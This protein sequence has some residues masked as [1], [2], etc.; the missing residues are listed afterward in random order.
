MFGYRWSEGGPWD[1]DNIQGVVR[2]LHRVWSLMTEQAPGG[3]AS[4]EVRR[5]LKRKLHQ[6][7]QRVTHDYET[8]EFNTI[9]AALMEL[10]NEM[11]AARERGAGGTPEWEEAVD[12]YLR[13]MAPIAPHIAE[14]LWTEYLGKPYSVHLQS[15][16]EYDPEAASEEEITLV[17]QVNGKVRDRV[18]VPAGISEER[19]R[20]VA[21]ASEPARRF[22]EGKE[23]REVIVVP[24]RLVNIVV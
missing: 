23:P 19:A 1:P 4:E 16:P 11:V 7:I 24:G 9:I 14:E 3:E 18:K 22:M 12:A 15:W 8:F 5:N 2:W 6:T 20:E 13:M 21:L 17:I 10:L